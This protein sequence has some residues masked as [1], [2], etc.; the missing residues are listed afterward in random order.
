MA[1]KGEVFDVI[2]FEQ[3][4]VSTRARFGRLLEYENVGGAIEG[5]DLAFEFVAQRC[6]DRKQAPHR[7]LL[8]VVVTAAVVPTLHFCVFLFFFLQPFFPPTPS[9]PFFLQPKTLLNSALSA[10]NVKLT[11]ACLGL[12]MMPLLCEPFSSLI[13][14]LVFIRDWAYQLV[15][16]LCYNIIYLLLLMDGLSFVFTL[17]QM[18]FIF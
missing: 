9:L 2:G 13:F 15:L 3:P 1:E 18:T 10:P 5:D 14:G 16:L 4:K 8:R 17:D 7:Q 12:L 11:N 6:P